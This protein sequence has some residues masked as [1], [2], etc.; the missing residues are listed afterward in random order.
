LAL[1][2]FFAFASACRRQ[3]ERGPE[4]GAHAAEASSTAEPPLPPAGGAELALVAPLAAGSPIG[5]FTVRAVH[6]VHNGM[7]RVV[8]VKDTA[9]VR[10]D[11]AL[12]D[13]S[14]GA[15]SPP[16]TAGRYAIYYA[17]RSATPEDGEQLA[18]R[19]AHVIKGNAS[20]PVPPGLAPFKPN[21]KPG[22][23]L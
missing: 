5:G 7:M 8:C 20:A 9:V 15:P 3:S 17:L 16:A 1:G 21:P 22:I 14:E 19:L 12:L 4:G 13:E 6:G 10:L 11:V 18:T 2:L 23:T